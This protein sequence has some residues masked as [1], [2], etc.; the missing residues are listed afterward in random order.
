MV[1]D[2][3]DPEYAPKSCADIANIP[4]EGVR[5][6]WYA[7]YR[8]EFDGLFDSKTLECVPWSEDAKVFQPAH[9][10]RHQA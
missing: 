5:A 10:L 9:P 7:A 4:D 8:K 3:T 6:E 2:V 1:A